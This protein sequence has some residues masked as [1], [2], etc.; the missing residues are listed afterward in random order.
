[1][2]LLVSDYDGTYRR[3]KSNIHLNNSAINKWMKK[4]HKF[5]LST[6]RPFPSIM[7]EI[8]KNN[9]P[10]DYL[11]C[12][13]GSIVFN[14]DNHILDAHYIEQD[15]Y[16]NLM[17][18]ACNESSVS[19]FRLVT[20]YEVKHSKSL[21]D[22]VLEYDLHLPSGHEDLSYLVSKTRQSL[23]RYLNDLDIYA[24]DFG[25]DDDCFI[26]I[27]SFGINKTT[28][29]KVIQDMYSLSTEKIYTIG[30][31]VNDLEMIHTY[32]G[33]RIKGSLIYEEGIPE[34]KNVREVV[35]TKIR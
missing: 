20:A 13:D 27:R 17:T 1:M 4:G 34:V 14:Q 21:D 7:E 28:S 5:M 22:Q 26:V 29:I 31:E 12:L 11:S 15:I 23:R 3:G 2:Q 30:D 6:G 10:Y 16:K 25:Q 19:D 18:L 9:I 35:R 33:Y 24:L 8:K 32:N